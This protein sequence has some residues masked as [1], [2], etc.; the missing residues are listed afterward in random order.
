MVILQPGQ[1]IRIGNRELTNI[2]SKP[3]I[4]TETVDVTI[5]PTTATLRIKIIREEDVYDNLDRLSSLFP[6]D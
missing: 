5:D 1:S 4:I 3:I 6:K 2:S